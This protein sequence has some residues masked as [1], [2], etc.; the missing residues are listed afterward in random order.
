[1]ISVSSN[2]FLGPNMSA[3]PEN[4]ELV[5]AMARLDALTDWERRLLRG[6]RVGLG[7]MQD[8]TALLGKPQKALRAVH[9]RLADFARRRISD[10]DPLARIVHER[11]LAGDMVLAHHR[12]QASFKT[13]K[14]IAEPAVAVAFRMGLSVFLPED[15]HRHA[16]PLQFARQGRP[17]RFDP[18]PLAG[19]NRG[20]PKELEFQSLL[21]D[22]VG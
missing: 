11:L 17:V 7:P 9:F 2:C 14:Q 21:G 13:T 19:R 16:R 18:P 1:M 22:V 4:R 5:A 10:P 6:M 3:M 12:R 20:A 8:L 15:R